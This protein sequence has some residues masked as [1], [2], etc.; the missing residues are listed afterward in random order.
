MVKLCRICNN[1]TNE[2]KNKA[3]YCS[4]QCAGV[5]RRNK[6]PKNCAICSKIFLVIKASYDRRKCC[7]KR[8]SSFFMKTKPLNHLV[9]FK[10]GLVP[11]NKG[12]L[13]IFHVTCPTCK[14]DFTYGSNTYKR[15]YCSQPCYHKSHKGEN[16]YQW[17]KDR[18]LIKRYNRRGDP[19]YR[20]WRKQI[21][22]RDKYKCRINNGDCRG[23]L[24]V[25][26]ILGWQS[27]PELRY[28][29]NNGIT[30]CHAHHPR[31]REDEV[32]LSPYFKN[33]VAEMQ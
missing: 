6:K 22:L 32:K 33:L 11:W 19:A 27:H 23:R 1:P 29:I 3:I 28:K 30:L 15:K 7:S 5:N 9:H 13:K 8:C 16:A 14:K 18:N 26:H 20:E 24:E 21:H 4:L 25:H 12:L 10:K 31:K 2:R 17:R